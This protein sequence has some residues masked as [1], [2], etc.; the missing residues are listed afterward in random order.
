MLKY[1][2]NL[3][4]NVMHLLSVL[5]HSSAFTLTA[6]YSWERGSLKLETALIRVLWYVILER[7]TTIA[8]PGTKFTFERGKRRVKL[9]VTV[10][11]C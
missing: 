3:G 8:A 5:N 1:E 11:L 6:L 4:G 7:N 2:K 10:I 9:T